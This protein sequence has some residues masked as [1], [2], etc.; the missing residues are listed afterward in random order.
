[1][2]RLLRLQSGQRRRRW[3]LKLPAQNRQIQDVMVV[4]AQNTVSKCSIHT[5]WGADPVGFGVN[6]ASNLGEVAVALG[7]KLNGGGLHEERVVGGIM[8]IFLI[9]F[10]CVI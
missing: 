1:M 9:R 7:D 6:E 2:Q 4:Q 3:L 8:H 5:H 10:I